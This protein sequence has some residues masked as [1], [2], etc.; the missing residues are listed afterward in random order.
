MKV[1]ILINIL[2]LTVCIFC[3]NAQ[4]KNDVDR[5]S[6]ITCFKEK[7]AEYLK[8]ELKLTDKEATAFIPLV[9]ELMD[10]KYEVNRK[11]RM[12][13][14]TLNR[15]KDKADDDYKTAINSMLNSQLQEA[16]LQKE[17]YQKFMDVLP[18]EKVYNYYQ[19]EMKFMRNMLDKKDR[20]HNINDIK[21][22]SGSKKSTHN[23]VNKRN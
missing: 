20:G 14:K 1:K 23:H 10:K 16:Q 8:Q 22:T 11:S 13:M 5:Q 19:V 21:V 2:F 6:K 15:K 3:A 4:Q 12:Y 17:Y 9:N 7:N 18:L